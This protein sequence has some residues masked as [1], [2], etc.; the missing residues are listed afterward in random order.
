M[1]KIYFLAT[2]MIAIGAT[3]GENLYVSLCYS[4]I[5]C[6]INLDY[7]FNSI[8]RIMCLAWSFSSGHI[9]LSNYFTTEDR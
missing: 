1:I 8:P 9:Y 2:A 5:G 6:E 7:F 3:S 4:A